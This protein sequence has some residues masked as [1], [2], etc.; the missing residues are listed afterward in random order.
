MRRLIIF[1]P[2][3]LFMLSLSVNSFQDDED[4]PERLKHFKPKYEET[5]DESFEVVWN[6]CKDAITQTACQIVTQK[7]SQ[8]DEGL[9]KG[10][11]K[12][13]YCIF[14]EG[15]DSS[16]QVCQRYHYDMPYIP[17][18]VWISGRVKYTIILKEQE[19]GKV[20]MVLSA[21]MSGF[22][23]LTYQVYFWKSNGQMEFAMIE[24]IKRLAKANK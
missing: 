10:T 1:V 6:A 22:E 20:N 4:I 11:I 18:S 17:G 12:S 21:E 8:T 15:S 23:K 16:Y 7:S 14:S 9:Y 19:D 3:M 24:E 2:I 5:F 13:D